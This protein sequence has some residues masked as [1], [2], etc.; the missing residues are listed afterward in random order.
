M[1]K[2]EIKITALPSR[3]LDTRLAA[4]VISIL[5]EGVELQNEKGS[6]ISKV[7][8]GPVRRINRRTKAQI[9]DISSREESDDR[10]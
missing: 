5:L 9:I 10:A 8:Q 3:N 7:Q 4:E 6:T 2:K 1:P